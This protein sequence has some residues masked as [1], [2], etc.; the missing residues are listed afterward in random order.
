[1]SEDAIK[2][3]Q[4]ELKDYL[5][6]NPHLK[7]FQHEIDRH[8]EELGDNPLLRMTFLMRSISIILR[9]EMI[10]AIEELEEKL[11]AIKAELI[12]KDAA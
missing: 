10:P 11:S 12:E 2:R 7:E 8:L 5:D 3:A 1:M 4:Q 6:E 9:D